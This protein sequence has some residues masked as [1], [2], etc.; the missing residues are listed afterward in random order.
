MRESHTLTIEEDIIGLDA[1]VLVDLVESDE[2]RREIKNQVNIGVLGIY[3][4]NVAFGEAGNVLVRD[5]NYPNIKSVESLENAMKE[6]NIIK[7]SHNK[8][9]NDL[10]YTWFEK[11]KKQ[12]YI[13]KIGT[14]LADC[15]ILA[16]LYDQ[17]NINMFMTEDRDVEKAINILNVPVKI[18]LVGEASN[19]T[20]FEIKRFF[21]E[22]HKD[23]RKYHKC[24]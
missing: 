23:H 12:I 7:I 1:N 6:F 14:F 17:V 3:T 19:L 8:E 24:F 13:K 9:G 22:K 5:R 10:G 18:I 4:T 11:A 15:R 16:N 2:F 20:D 21:K